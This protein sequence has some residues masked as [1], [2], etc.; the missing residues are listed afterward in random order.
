MSRFLYNSQNMLWGNWMCIADRDEGDLWKSRFYWNY[1]LRN[2]RANREQYGFV[3]LW[4]RSRSMAGDPNQEY[5]LGVD[6]SEGGRF[7]PLDFFEGGSARTYWIVGVVKDG[8]GTPLGG[9]VVEIFLT[10]SDTWVSS[11]TTDSN[12][13]YAIGTPYIGQQHYAVANY[14]PN[15][16]VGASVN[17][18]TP[19]SNPW[20]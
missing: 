20:G 18:L 19:G 4:P 6:Q 10:A 11:G 16:L 14:G 8:G 3:S 12:G 17:T 15:T 9:A 1:H 13:I 7:E 2:T 5:I